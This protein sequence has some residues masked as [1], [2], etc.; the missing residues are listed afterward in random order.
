MLGLFV[1]VFK[2][3]IKAMKNLLILGYYFVIECLFSSVALKNAGTERN[4]L[5]VNTRIK[6]IREVYGDNPNIMIYALSDLTDEN[7]ITPDWVDIFFKMW[8]GIFIKIQM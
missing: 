4:P 3:S 7:D 2:H 1:D 5:N 6:M 8:I